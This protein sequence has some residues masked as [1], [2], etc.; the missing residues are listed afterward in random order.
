MQADGMKDYLNAIG[1]LPLLTADQE[2]ELARKVQAMMILKE[3]NRDY[4][5]QEKRV[6]KI[7]ERAKQKMIQC[8]LR[9]VVSLARRYTRRLVC[10][11]ME[12]LDLIQ[13]GNIGLDRAVEKFD[14]ARGYKFSTYAYWWIRQS[15]SRAIDMQE[16][17]VRVP[18]NALEKAYKARIFQH[19]FQQ[20]TGR[21]PTI[22]ETAK[23]LDTTEESLRMVFERV[24]PHTSLDCNTTEGGTTLIDLIADQHGSDNDHTYEEL[25]E[26]LEKFELA[27]LTL[28]EE[29]QAVLSAFYGLNGKDEMT[30]T[31]IAKAYGVSRESVRQQRL[32]AERKIKL[33]MN[34][35]AVQKKTQPSWSVGGLLDSF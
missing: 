4:T 11:S 17:A 5:Q 12:L 13:E 27:F 33:K 9:L 35:F 31:E 24:T 19:E 6:I 3:E 26:L 34:L 29:H 23:H 15:I 18:A 22:K 10:N 8:N 7:G 30:L 21:A 25:N 28:S 2:I 32:K 14:P 20:T 16:R 1:S